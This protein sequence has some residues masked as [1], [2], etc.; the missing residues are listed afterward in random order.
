MDIA[1]N[2]E[3]AQF[4]L[5]VSMITRA[6]TF[7]VAELR[8]DNMLMGMS[9]ERLVERLAYYYD[10]FNYI[11]PF[12]EGNGRTQRVFWSRIAYDAGWR[13]DWRAVRG[14]TN[15]WASRAAAEEG[16][17]GPLLEM[18]NQIVVDIG[19]ERGRGVERRA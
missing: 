16:D 3:G 17:L 14:S 2:V 15:D 5:P 9:R 10:A 1:K 18:L 7:T 13:L 6:S 12:R 11:H 8:G 4:F 19:D